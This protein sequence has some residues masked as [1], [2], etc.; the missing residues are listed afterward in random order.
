MAAREL[1]EVNLVALCQQHIAQ[2]SAGKQNAIA[3]AGKV[4]LIAA[5][6]QVEAKRQLEDCDELFGYPVGLKP[7][8]TARC[9]PGEY[10]NAGGQRASVTL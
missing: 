3:V 6:I 5:S 1:L 2:G 4:N 7:R 10:R 9:S 8:S